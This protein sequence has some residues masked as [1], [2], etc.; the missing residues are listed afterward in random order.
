M[1]HYHSD[2]HGHH[3]HHHRPHY[4]QPYVRAASGRPRSLE[5]RCSCDAHNGRLRSRVYGQL[6]SCIIPLWFER[7]QFVWQ[8]FQP[9]NRKVFSYFSCCEFWLPWPPCIL[10]A[11]AVG[12]A[13][14]LF[15]GLNYIIISHS[16]NVCA[17][18]NATSKS[19]RR[20]ERLR[21]H[22]AWKS[23]FV[24]THTNPT[25]HTH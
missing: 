9:L 21:A 6:T 20:R 24:S 13:R 15:V 18:K 14:R 10:V 19:S 22:H 11:I 2:D 16:G 4:G 3:H 5:C 17:R 25:A 12:W 7:E 8:R 1:K 23:S